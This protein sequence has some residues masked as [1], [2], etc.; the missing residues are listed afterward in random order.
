MKIKLHNRDGAKLFLEQKENSD[1]WNLTVDKEHE[2]V[3]NYM[4]II[5]K[6][7]V[8]DISNPLNWEAIDPAGGPFIRIES[9]FEGYRVKEFL[10]FT[11]LRCEKV[12]D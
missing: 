6:E 3:L 4:R 10:D 2:Y 5:G 7:N 12:T 9:I 8:N 1:I 11:T